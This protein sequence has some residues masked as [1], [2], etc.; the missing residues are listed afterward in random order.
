MYA[1]MDTAPDRTFAA[2]AAV[3]RGQVTVDEV[4][5]S[6]GDAGLQPRADR[7]IRRTER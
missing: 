6:V 4:A 3:A 1:I 5:I 2:G 7:P